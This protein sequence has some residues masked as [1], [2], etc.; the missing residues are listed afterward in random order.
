MVRIPD[1]PLGKGQSS[2]RFWSVFSPIARPLRSECT[3]RAILPV[4]EGARRHRSGWRFSD[5]LGSHRSGT[6]AL[7]ARMLLT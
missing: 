3:P 4:N 5:A 7:S 1:T 2:D 6:R